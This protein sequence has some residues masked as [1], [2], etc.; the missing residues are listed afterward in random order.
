LIDVAT[1]RAEWTEAG[2]SG[3]PTLLTAERAVAAVSELLADRTADWGEID[4]AT[5]F[6]QLAFDSIELA[7]L[8]MLLE[9]MLG[10]AIDTG[11]GETLTVVGDLTRL[12]TL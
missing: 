5:P 4:A 7:E 12:R 2:E 8:F 1:C 10:A 6:D 9:E 11:C 3:A